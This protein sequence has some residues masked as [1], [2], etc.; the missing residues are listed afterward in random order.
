MLTILIPSDKLTLTE[1]T[2][3]QTPNHMGQTL[4]WF[5]IWI[6]LNIGLV[7]CHLQS[8]ALTL[9]QTLTIL[10]LRIGATVEMFL[11]VAHYWSDFL[12]SVVG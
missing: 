10:H 1:S 7:L 8:I 2:P 12:G 6:G 3:T 4:D 9:T 11:M 5:G